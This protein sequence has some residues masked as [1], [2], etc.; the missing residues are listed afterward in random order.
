[1]QAAEHLEVVTGSQRGWIDAEEKV[2]SRSCR[3]SHVEHRQAE[4][5]QPEPP[6]GR[7]H[8]FSCLPARAEHKTPPQYMTYV[9]CFAPSSSHGHGEPAVDGSNLAQQRSPR[10][11]SSQCAGFAG[12][13]PNSPR[14]APNRSYSPRDAPIR[15]SPRDAPVRSYSPRDAPAR[16]SPRDAPTRYSPRDKPVR[17]YSHSEERHREWRN[18]IDPRAH[19]ADEVRQSSQG[20]ASDGAPA[21]GAAQKPQGLPGNRQ[22][23]RFALALDTINRSDRG[24]E[25]NRKSPSSASRLT[26]GALDYEDLC[27]RLTKVHRLR[28]GLD[29]DEH[30]PE[31]LKARQLALTFWPSLQKKGIELEAIFNTRP[32]GMAFNVGRMPCVVKSIIV[33]SVAGSLGVK[34]G[35]VI[36]SIDGEDVTEMAYEVFYDKFS[37]KCGSLRYMAPEIAKE[38]IRYSS[39]SAM[40]SP[41]IH[42]VHRGERGRSPRSQGGGAAEPALREAH[43]N[44]PRAAPSRG[45]AGATSAP[46]R[47]RCGSRAPTAGIPAPLR[48][49]RVVPAIF[50]LASVELMA[51]AGPM[52]QQER[53][54]SVGP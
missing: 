27:R 21:G 16:Y 13:A 24:D 5:G 39:T 9:S 31:D 25:V 46:W 52:S 4:R 29:L 2:D 10:G 26:P 7:I 18:G 41:R 49:R 44:E 43:R 3:H 34:K 28:R 1:M 40:Q 6:A 35:M 19:S 15:Y 20:S 22:S 51:Y 37:R 30:A 17:S 8:T 50:L 47:R 32:L 12:F 14:D 23:H 48:A 38:L 53:P 54:I 36:K 11:S 42:E 33:G 45:V